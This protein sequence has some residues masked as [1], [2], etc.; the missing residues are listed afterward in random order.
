VKR[1]THERH[2]SHARR[3]F[4]FPSG[5]SSKPSPPPMLVMEPASRKQ[6]RVSFVVKRWKRGLASVEVFETPLCRVGNPARQ[7]IG[8]KDT[9][10][11]GNLRC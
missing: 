2:A 9:L 8:Q 5:A 3:P 11:I 6:S 7:N 10:L 1:E 4:I